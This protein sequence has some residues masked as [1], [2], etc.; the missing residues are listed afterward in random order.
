M[1]ADNMLERVGAAP[2]WVKFVA[3][4][5][6]SF[7]QCC[8]VQVDSS[9]HQV[10]WCWLVLCATQKPQGVLLQRAVHVLSGDLNE[11]LMQLAQGL[12]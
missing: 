1:P 3:E 5:R 11:V 7:S 4:N 2:A 9:T 6:G 12:S 10:E 8:L